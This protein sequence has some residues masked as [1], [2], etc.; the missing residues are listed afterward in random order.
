MAQTQALPHFCSELCATEAQ[1]AGTYEGRW[2]NT[3]SDA[4]LN[5]HPDAEEHCDWC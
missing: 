5:A 3:E 1:E 2:V 4:Y